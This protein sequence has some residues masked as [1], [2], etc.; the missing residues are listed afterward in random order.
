MQIGKPQRCL[1]LTTG[2]FLEDQFSQ[3]NFQALLR[4]Y[5]EI[6]MEQYVPWL[7]VKYYM[8]HETWEMLEP[9]ECYRSLTIDHWNTVSFC[10]LSIRP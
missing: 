2:D 5:G 1:I 3:W 6:L 7:Q 9:V 8:N 4:E 10:L